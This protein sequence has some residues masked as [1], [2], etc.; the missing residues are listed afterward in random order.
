MSGLTGSYIT[1]YALTMQATTQQI[2][3]LSSLPNFA[4][5]IIQLIAPF[6]S[7]RV[8][9][10]KAFL[11]PFVLT[12]AI[13]WL[14]ILAIPFLFKTNQF[15]WLLAFMTLSTAANAL[16]GPPWSSMMADLVPTEI[17]GHYFG[18]RNRI[19][20]FVTLLFSFLSGGLLQLFT[21]NTQL[22][23]IM[24]FSGAFISRLISFNF[25]SIMLE[26]HPATAK[27]VKK[28]SILQITKGLS[29]T[30]IGRIIIYFFFLN[31]ACNIAGPFF[32]PY[33]LKE[34]QFNY[35]TY[36]VIN[37]VTTIV[38]IFIVTWW[39]KRA[40]KAGSLKIL[41]I[42]GFM[43]PIVPLLWLVSSSVYWIFF[44]QAFSG[45]AW[46]GFNLCIGLFVYDASPQENRIRYIA[47]HGALGAIGVTIGSLI[48][49]TIGP[50]LPLIKGSYYL[51]LFLISGVARFIVAAAFLRQV[52]EVRDVAP[53]KVS[54]ILF[55]SIY[56]P[57]LTIWLK[58]FYE[59]VKQAIFRNTKKQ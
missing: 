26:P 19:M 35:I 13:L 32:A 46:G 16:T 28:E 4:N 42:T 37:A 56:K 55:G 17:R 11:L 40:D 12:Q 51:T 23:F 8:K 50:H 58:T 53:T 38:T 18:E 36:Q 1:P 3:Y 47:L 43:V 21:N 9:S 49:G 2:G 5:T 54:D 48:G 39:G 6:L 25:L 14:P 20:N 52:S 30:N 7:E 57:S 31:I 44:A 27:N 33:M 29:N 10:R 22:A 59:K 45:I 24:I 15:W 41:R 34:L